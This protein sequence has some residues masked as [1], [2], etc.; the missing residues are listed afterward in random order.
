MKEKPKSRSLEPREPLSWGFHGILLEL[1]MGMHI[2][3]DKGRD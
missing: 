2:T 3:Q 1:P